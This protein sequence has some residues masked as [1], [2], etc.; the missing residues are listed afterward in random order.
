MKRL[1]WSRAMGSPHTSTMQMENA[2]DGVRCVDISEC[3]RSMERPYDE[4]PFAL[5]SQFHLFMLNS[6]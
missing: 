3:G 5:S 4:I 2:A 6:V 1:Q